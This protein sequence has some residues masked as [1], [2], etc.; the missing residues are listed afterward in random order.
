MASQEEIDTLV[1]RLRL[2]VQAYDCSNQTLLSNEDYNQM[3]E[4]LRLWDPTN[5]FFTEHQSPQPREIEHSEPILVPNRA[6]SRD[7]LKQFINLSEQTAKETGM[8]TPTFR[9]TIKI[10]GMAAKDHNDILVTRRSGRTGWVV[11][12]IFDLGV[13]P[14]G[15]RN[16]GI[17][18]IVMSQSYF[19]THLSDLFCHPRNV[20]VICVNAPTLRKEVKQALKAKAIHFMPYSKLA[21]W[22]GSGAELLANIQTI[23]DDLRGNLDYPLHG[24]RIEVEDPRIKEKLGNP[25]GYYRWQL[26]CPYMECF[27]SPIA[28]KRI[29]FTGK[30]Q[31]MRDDMETNARELG[32]TVTVVSESLDYL[33]VGERAS[34]SK[35]DKA[36]KYGATV[37]TE[38]EYRTLISQ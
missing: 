18:E 29:C 21:H 8:D 34:Q 22:T 23:Y 17:G 38:V 7:S 15:G 20:V 31:Q 5:V 37:L 19:D 28:G 36:N 11:T 24:L 3:V 16:Q 32:A 6:L 26:D 9:A 12:H 1:E 10:D 35:I 2:C 25:T 14:I 13:V 30:M 33:V 4:Q 27:D